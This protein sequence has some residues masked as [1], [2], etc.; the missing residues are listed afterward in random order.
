MAGSRACLPQGMALVL[1]S[2]QT[3]IHRLMESINRLMGGIFQEEGFIPS[4]ISMVEGGGD[5]EFLR[6]SSGFR[7]PAIDA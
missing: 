2:K 7:T 1:V 4:S 6:S 3:N 5:K